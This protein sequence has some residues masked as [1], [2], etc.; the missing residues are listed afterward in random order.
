MIRFDKPNNF[1]GVQFC[2]E[3]EAAGVSINKDTSPLIDG[4]GDFWLDIDAKDTTKAQQVLDAHKPKPRP[5]PTVAEKLASV[6]LD[7]DDLKSA[8]GL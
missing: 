4:N 5:E 8:L 3:L 1:E 2:E 6:G 7:L